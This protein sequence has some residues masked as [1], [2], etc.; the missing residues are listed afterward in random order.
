MRTLS[1]RQPWAWLIT[2]GHMPLANRDEST[3]FRGRFLVH[4]GLHM[5]QRD[6]WATADRLK[7]EMH[8]EVPHFLELPR[9]GI[10]GAATLVDVVTEHDSPFFLGP[11]GFVL[12]QA[13]SIPFVEVTG[14]RGWFSTPRAVFKEMA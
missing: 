4:A 9:G 13:V 2:N 6:Y 10:V 12:K 14:Q 1:I 5:V 11:I 8:I 3:D 7:A